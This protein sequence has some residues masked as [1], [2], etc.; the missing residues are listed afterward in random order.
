MRNND[1]SSGRDLGK[2]AGSRIGLALCLATSAACGEAQPREQTLEEGLALQAALN[3]TDLSV[4][5]RAAPNP[6]SAGGQLLYAINVGNRTNPANRV[7]AV[8]TLPSDVS[9][10]LGQEDCTRAGSTLR[11]D[12]GSLPGTSNSP[13]ALLALVSAGAT[14]Q[15]LTS[16][17][18]VRH[19]Y[20]PFSAQSEVEGP[21]PNLANNTAS[22]TVTVQ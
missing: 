12:L 22:V 8:L 7:R 20:T 4:A 1:V 19:Y 9:L 10:V 15:K 11:C 2:W 13:W 6:V 16:Q 21:D 3:T 17:I 5:I 14:E 18:T